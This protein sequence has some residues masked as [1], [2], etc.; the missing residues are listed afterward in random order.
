MQL[1]RSFRHN[2]TEVPPPASTIGATRDWVSNARPAVR[3]LVQW[4][5]T[6]ISDGPTAS[7]H[8]APQEHTIV[9][10]LHQSPSSG[11]EQLMQF[12]D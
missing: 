7:R 8:T 1:I 10:T 12:T 11:T 9:G 6:L 4:Q 2:T 3:Q 5:M